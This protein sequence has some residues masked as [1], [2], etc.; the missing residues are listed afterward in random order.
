MR[1]TPRSVPAGSGLPSSG[2]IGSSSAAVRD[3]S[4][5][6]AKSFS[7]PNRARSA[8]SQ[9]G[10]PLRR[11]AAAAASICSSRMQA[12][13]RSGSLPR[14]SSERNAAIPAPEALL[15]RQRARIVDRHDAQLGRARC[16]EGRD[17][18]L[19]ALVADGSRGVIRD[20]AGGGFVEDA[21]RLAGVVAPDQPAVGIVECPVD[22][23][24]RTSDAR[25]AHSE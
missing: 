9:S 22:A 23:G 5:P 7:Q 2:S 16:G 6:S 19:V 1:K 13:I 10:S 8:P 21:G 20:E 17:E 11:P 14:S 24:G 3:A 25:L 12:W 18:P 15:Q 4:V